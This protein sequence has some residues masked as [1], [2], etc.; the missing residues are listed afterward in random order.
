[1]IGPG[2]KISHYE[3]LSALGKGLHRDIKPAN[4][5]ITERGVA[6]LLDFGLAHVLTAG[7]GDAPTMRGL[8]QAG[9]ALG[10]VSYMSPEQ[11]RG[12]EL[13]ARSDLF[14]LGVVLYEMVTGRPA[15]TGQ[16][17]AAILEQIF[18]KTVRLPAHLSPR[19]PERTRRHH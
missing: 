7:V 9:V 2:T 4:I 3:V 16:T 5:F 11:A 6:K 15:F 12:E 18:S 14:A 8:T 1:M 17:S 13:D 19:R 10:T